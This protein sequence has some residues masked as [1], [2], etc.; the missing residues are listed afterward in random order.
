MGGLMPFFDPPKPFDEFAGYL[1]NQ[2]ITFDGAE[3]QLRGTRGNYIIAN[4]SPSGERLID[5]GLSDTDLGKRL[6]VHEREACWGWNE[7]GRLVVCYRTVPGH[8]FDG[9]KE[10]HLVETAV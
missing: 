5:S 6:A 2:A 8:H 1:F 3:Q 10:R 4:R 9:Y 7:A